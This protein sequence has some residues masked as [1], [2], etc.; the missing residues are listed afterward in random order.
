MNATGTERAILVGL[1][2]GARWELLLAAE[3]PDRVLGAAFVGVSSPTDVVE[4]YDPATDQWGVVKARMPTPRSA[5][6]SAS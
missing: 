1:S 4:E 5:V 3:H 6:A 2:A